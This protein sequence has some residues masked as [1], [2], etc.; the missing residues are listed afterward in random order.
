MHSPEK[1]LEVPLDFSPEKMNSSFAEFKQD[2][3]EFET[4]HI[5][6]ELRDLEYARLDWHD[7]IYLDYTGGGLYANSQ[8][9]KHM[10][11]LRCNVFG[12]PHSDNP[13]SIA[14]TKLVERAR[15]KILSF[16]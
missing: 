1:Y 10:E 2:Y 13:T 14:M 15:I 3:P 11:L 4:T 5:L 7:Q 8:L 9:L 12:N 6:D 16:F